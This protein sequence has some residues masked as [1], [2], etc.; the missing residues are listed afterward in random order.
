MWYPCFKAA[1]VALLV[2]NT[3]V[4]LWSGTRSEALDSSAWLVV[5]L[6]FELETGLEKRRIGPRVALLARACRLGATAALAAATIGYV[7]ENEWLDA[8]NMGVW[9]ALVALLDIQ[10]RHPGIAARRRSVFTAGAAM[11]YAALAALALAWA[12]RGEW[13]DAYDAL[14]WLIAFATIEMNIFRKIRH[15]PA[16]LQAAP[17]YASLKALAKRE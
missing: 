15:H 16:A 17:E 14:L 8:V 4:Y 3:A 12:W 10:V 5:L 9:V 11:L 1:L 7:G 13:F 6:S 2:W